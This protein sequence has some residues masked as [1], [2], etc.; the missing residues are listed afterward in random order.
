MSEGFQHAIAGG[1]GKLV[2]T[3]LQSPDF[4]LAA[5]TGWAIYRNGD[6][7]FFNVTATGA[8]TANTVIIDG[9]GD[10]L[11]IYEGLPAFGTLIL[12]AASAGGTDDYGNE[13]TG[14]GI[15]VSYPGLG[16]NIIQVRP[17]KG[18]IFLYAES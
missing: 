14:P 12:S 8:V 7:Y 1:Q 10:G 5:Q 2:V 18:A 15:S 3:Q 16:T 13:Y 11:F 17:D 4:S 6:A 9:A